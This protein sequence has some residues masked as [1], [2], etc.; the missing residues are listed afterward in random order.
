MRP[1]IRIPGLPALFFAM[2]LNCFRVNGQTGSPIPMDK[3][4]V[5]TGSNIKRSNSLFAGVGYG[6]NM[7]W[8]GST[9]SGNHPYYSAALTYGFGKGLYLTASSSYVTGLKLFPSFYCLS[10][11]YGHSVNKWF[12]ISSSLAGYKTR[13]A[14]RDTLFSDFGYVNF[15]TGFDWKILYTRISLSGVISEDLKGYIQIINSRYFKTGAFLNGDSYVSFNPEFSILAGEI[16]EIV[17]QTGTKKY[18]LSP[19]FR[20]Y[21]KNSTVTTESYTSKFGVIDFEFSVPVDFNYKSFSIELEP[22]FVLPA[23]KNPEYPAPD[24]FSV[25]ISIYLRII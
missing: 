4:S 3:D 5:R 8:L 25:Y 14:L 6:S 20:H 2:L 1:L 16:I 9:I 18:G 21:K 11:S 15:I 23:Y 12:D 22:G 24:G 17:T 19:P 10:S 13:E 7:I